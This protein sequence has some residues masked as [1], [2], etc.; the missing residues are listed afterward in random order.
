MQEGSAANTILNHARSRVAL[1]KHMRV[2][3]RVRGRVLLVV[4]VSRTVDVAC[5]IQKCASLKAAELLPK[6]APPRLH[7]ISALSMELMES[8]R[9]QVAPLV[10]QMLK[11]RI[12]TDT[13]ETR[14]SRAPCRVAPPPLSAKVYVPNT[15]VV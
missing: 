13:V 11:K 10:C 7:T 5:D 15:A 12:A 1:P 6:K 8:A 9:L 4:C 2:R 14:G 3:V